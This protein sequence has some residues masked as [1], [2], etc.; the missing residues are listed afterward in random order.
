MLIQGQMWIVTHSVSTVSV[1]SGLISLVFKIH[2]FTVFRPGSHIA[3]FCSIWSGSTLFAQAIQIL[4]VIFC[5]GYISETTNK[6]IITLYTNKKWIIRR[7]V[8]CK[9]IVYT[10][11]L[12][13]YLMLSMLSITFNIFKYFSFI[14]FIY[15]F[16]V[17]VFCMFCFLFLQEI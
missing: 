2:H 5:L 3:T 8:M 10:V 1:G 11:A 6:I 16:F 4:T 7:C 15:F 17:C 14:L 9:S 13:V 12:L